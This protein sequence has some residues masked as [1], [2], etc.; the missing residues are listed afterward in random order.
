M[1]IDIFKGSIEYC[2]SNKPFF[3]LIFGLFLIIAV[4]IDVLD[5][6]V[7]DLISLFL[8]VL[9][10][11]YCL[12]II[13]DVIN[14]GTR[15]PK[16]IPKKVII[17]GFKG[18]VIFT[19]YSTIQVTLLSIV[20]M[21]LGFPEFDLEELYADP[22]IVLNM[23]QGHD[24]VMYIIF[25]FLGFAISYLIIFF[26]ELSLAKLADGE[27]LRDSFNFRKIKHAIDIIGWDRYTVGYTKIIFILMILSLITRFTTPFDDINFIVGAF[28]LF[29]GFV[30]ECR[31]MGNVYRV[32]V[33]HKNST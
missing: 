21:M 26:M 11:G 22:L 20:S 6:R 15:L 32:Y 31:G 13:Q 27:K 16:I 17:L 7:Y 5:G 9:V 14:G 10:G 1:P 23:M 19:F 8:L 2:F 30:V 25:L 28:T 29:L 12:Q 3:L 33:E 24:L 4:L 18:G